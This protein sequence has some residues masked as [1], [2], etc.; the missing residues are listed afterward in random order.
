MEGNGNEI[1]AIQSTCI[2]KKHRGLSQFIV[3]RPMRN[4]KKMDAGHVTLDTLLTFTE[5]QSYF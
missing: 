1:R 5:P 4:K 3:L 2:L